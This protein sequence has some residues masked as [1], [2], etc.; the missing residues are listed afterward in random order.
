M[1]T[2]IVPLKTYLIV[3]AG[4]IALTLVTVEVARLDLGPFNQIVALLVAA[5]KTTLVAL[6][7]MHVRYSRPMVWLSIFCGLLWVAL[8]IGLTM[9][10][11]SSRTWLGV[12]RGF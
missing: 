1:S 7:F 11:F 5:V 6:I 9:V 2:H 12:P 4:L 8:L 10:D 3:F